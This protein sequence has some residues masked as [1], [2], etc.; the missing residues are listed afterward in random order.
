MPGSLI[1]SGKELATTCTVVRDWPAHQFKV[2]RKRKA[3][4]AVM[5]HYTAGVRPPEKMFGKLQGDG[6][7]VHLAVAHDGTVH[8]FCDL[9]RRCSHAGS[10]NDTNRDGVVASANAYTIGIEVICPGHNLTPAQRK[11]SVIASGAARWQVLLEEVHGTTLPTATF[12]QAQ[13]EAV[14]ELVQVLCAHY[15]LPVAVPMGPDGRVLTSVMAEDDFTAFRGVVPHYVARLGKRDP[16][17]SPMR[18]I[19]SLPE[20][21]KRRPAE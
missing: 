9:D 5:L 19:A 13:T 2:V 7:S 4:H 21:G 3:T 15:G 11:Q 8:Q 14:L 16:G 18:A 17:P 1:A 12:T 6:L 10:V 20:R